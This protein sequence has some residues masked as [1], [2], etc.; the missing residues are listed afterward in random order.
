MDDR[1]KTLAAIAIIVGFFLLVAII[2]GSLVA[3]SKIL[4]PIPEESGIKI[5]FI[6]PTAVQSRATPAPTIST[7]P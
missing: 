7:K 1:K 4:S 6:T 2:V 3:K 5:I